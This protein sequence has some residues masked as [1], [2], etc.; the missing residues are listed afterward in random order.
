[1]LTLQQLIERIGA[2]YS[3]TNRE[4]EILRLSATGMHTKAVACNLTCSPKTVEEHWRRILRKT[5]IASRSE[6]IALVLT[7]AL[8]SPV[9][10]ASFPSRLRV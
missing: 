2:R 6:V 1:M 5:R 10:E 8:A 9:R 4:R 7:E 3:L